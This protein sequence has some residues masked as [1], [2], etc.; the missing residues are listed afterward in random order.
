MSRKEQELK[1]VL[2]EILS[3]FPDRITIE[4]ITPEEAYHIRPC[5]I[6]KNPR[7]ADVLR[8]IAILDKEIEK[9]G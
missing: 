6:K 7:V 9:M 1:K 5:P 4:E 8:W 2:Q 3:Y